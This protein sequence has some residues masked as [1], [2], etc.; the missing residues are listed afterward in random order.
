MQDILMY[1]RYSALEYMWF[2]W[3]VWQQYLNSIFLK[4]YESI[5]YMELY[6]NYLFILWNCPFTFEH[7]TVYDVTQPVLVACYILL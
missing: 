7:H 2:Q 5:E 4:V 6:S 3:A 1:E